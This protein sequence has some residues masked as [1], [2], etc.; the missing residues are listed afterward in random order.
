MTGAWL[1]IAHIVTLEVWS[2]PGQ[3]GHRA[4]VRQGAERISPSVANIF[5]SQ[6]HYSG[7]QAGPRIP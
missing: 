7:T 3:K 1:T 5:L 6:I 2:K 4:G